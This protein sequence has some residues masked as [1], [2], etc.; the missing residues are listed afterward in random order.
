MFGESGEDVD[1]M[2]LQ[3]VSCSLVPYGTA[4]MPPI[5]RLPLQVISK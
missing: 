2:V 5:K 1:N 3:V 4:V